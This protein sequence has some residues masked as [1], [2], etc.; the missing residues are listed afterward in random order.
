MWLRN[1]VTVNVA[2]GCVIVPMKHMPGDIQ[3]QIDTRRFVSV[4]TIADQKWDYS[5][6]S[7]GCVQ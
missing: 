5:M 4:F 3:N 1:R 7:P 2:N 6:L